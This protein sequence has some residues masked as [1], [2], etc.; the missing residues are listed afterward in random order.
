M[1]TVMRAKEVREDRDVAEARM[2]L[3]VRVSTPGSA[4]RILGFPSFRRSSVLALRVP[5]S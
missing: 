1:V 4:P 5:I 2:V 3:A